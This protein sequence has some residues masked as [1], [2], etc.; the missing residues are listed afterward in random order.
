MVIGGGQTITDNGTINVGASSTVALAEANNSTT[1]IAVN[2]TLNAT[3]ATFDVT[4]NAINA[5]VTII[6]VN[7]GGIITPTGS[8]FSLP[9][10]VPYNDVAALAAGNN[11][12]F[13]QIEI[14]AGSIASGTLELDQIVIN[15]AN[16]IYVFPAGFT[17]GAGA[18]LTIGT[19]VSVVIGGGQT[20]TDNGTL[21]VGASRHRAWLRRTTRPP[22]SRSTARSMP[23]APSSTSPA[24]PSTPFV[25]I[26]QVNT[27]G[28]ITPTGSTFSL[29]L[30]VPYNDVAALA[31][32]NNQSFDQIKIDAGTLASGTVHLD[33][34]GINSANL[35]Y[36]FPAGFTIQSGAT[37]AIGTGV[38]VVVGGG[39][40]ITD[41]G[42]LNVGMPGSTVGLA[43]AN[44]STTEIAVNGTLNASGATFDITGS[45]INA[46]V[47]E[48]EVNSGGTIN[49]T[50]STFSVK[51]LSLNSGSTA[52][53][54]F[55]IF[56]GQLTVNSGATISISENTFSTTATVAAL[57]TPAATINLQNNYWTTTSAT[58]IASQIKDHSTDATRPTVSFQPFVNATAKTLAAGASAPYTTA[59]QPVALSATVSS[60]AG[61]VS[62]G[63]ETFT[64]LSGTTTI[65][66]PMMVNV[67]AGMAAANYV[68]PAGTLGGV[69]TIQ[70]I[71]NGTANFLGSIDTSQVLTVTGRA[72]GY[73][74]DRRE[75]QRP[76]SARQPSRSPSPPPSPARPA[77]STRGRRPSRFSTARH[78]SVPPSWAASP[79]ASPA[80]GYTLPAGTPGGTYTIQ[81]VYTDTVTASF[82]GSMDSS[83]LLTVVPAATSTAADDASAT[84]SAAAQSI[85]LSATV[86]SPAGAVNEGTETF[87]IF[88]GTSPIGTAVMG[89]V[90]AGVANAS[91]NLPAG[92]EV[93]TYT[94]QAA[95]TATAD[96][97]GSSENAHQL[98]VSTPRAPTTTAATDV[99]ATFS[100]LAQSV[101]LTA[102]ITSNTAG[103]VNEGT[104]TFTILEGS[105]TIGTPVTVNVAAGAASTSYGL[106]AGTAPGMYTIKA[107]YIGTTNFAG[108]SDTSHQLTINK[109]TAGTAA[110]GVMTTFSASAQSVDLSATITSGAGTVNEGTET[111]TASL[112][113]T[114]PIGPD[115]TVN[116]TAG[117]ASAIYALPA[118]TPGGTYIIQAV[119]NGTTNFLGF[120]DKSQQ[121]TISA[122]MTATDTASASATFNGAAQN[123]TLNTTITSTAGTVNEGTETFTIFSGTTQI[124]VAVTVNVTA[125]AASAVYVLPAGT[126]GG[127]YIIQAVYTGTTNFLGFTDKSQQFSISAVPSAT[128]AASASAAVS[129]A[130]QNVTLSATITSTAGTVN[131]GTETFTIFIGTTQIGLE[132]TVYVTDGG[133]SDLYVLPAGT[134]SGTYIIQAVYNGTTNFL[135]FTDRSQQL[136]ISTVITATAAASASATF[137][138]AAQNVTLSATITSTAGTVNEGTETF[139]IFRGT[140]QIG[141]AVTVNVIAGA[142][143]A[144]YVLPAGLPSGT[145]IIQAV[146]NGT[147]NF[148][149]FTEKTHLLTIGAAPSA[150]AAASASATFSAVAQNVTLSATIT[151]TA[152]T[153][154]EGT[155]TFTILDGTTPIGVAV[156]VN[157]TAGAASAV[158]VLPAGTPGGTYIIQAVYSGTT[159]FLGFTD[160]SQQLTI[161]PAATATAAASISTTFNEAA[162]NITLNATI[163]SGAGTVNEGTETFTILDGTTPIGGAVMVNVPAS[164]AS[165]V[166]VLP[167]G[168][169]GG[170]YII[171]AVYSA[172]TN[173]LGFTDKSQQLTISPAAFM[174]ATAAASISTT[175]NEGAHRKRDA[176]RHDHRRRRYGQR[177]DQRH[178]TILSGTTQIGVAVTANVTDGTASAVY[179]V[180]GGTPTGTYI[181]QAVYSATTNFLGFTDKTHQLTISPAATAT[182]AASISTTFNEAAQNVTLNATITSAAGTVNEGTETFTILSGTTTVGVAVTANVTDGTAS[183]VYVLPGGLRRPGTY[184]IQAVYSATTSFLGF[185]DKTHQLNIIP[186]TTTTKAA[187]LSAPYSSSDQSLALSA[188]ITSAA[189]IVNEGTE[190]FT[191]L[192]NSTVIG[193]PVTVNVTNAA[194]PCQLHLARRHGGDKVHHAIKDALALGRATSPSQAAHRR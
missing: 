45:A 68:L 129:A 67:T 140:T 48:I 3:S 88:S 133:V 158:Y 81:A 40:T 1:E 156:M 186:A 183:A 145:Y 37:L 2:G 172:T 54:H 83:A 39:Q 70:A 84:F 187:S 123:V 38:S 41:N 165:A 46:P 16:L 20:I 7:P 90:T 121:F 155:E 143:S 180:P 192:S 73:N 159:N 21:S 49:T 22:R 5:P 118:G 122:V 178:F 9:L 189:G 167:A 94:I 53:L 71:Y 52:T 75:Q 127:I 182:A 58:Q 103:T 166:Y 29:P 62:E 134:P 174:T 93:G 109:A 102:N 105:T 179:V 126:P 25:T 130:A 188:T 125:G 100:T 92:T 64:I 111:F 148:P 51:P 117:T 6:Q 149:G 77:P 128:A 146:Y 33:Q 163:T 114:T 144:D 132:V 151:S 36:V 24:T 161:S 160:K 80:P 61:T 169:S 112:S 13:N 116:V 69:Y 98:T 171:Q 106:P 43:E 152:G 184:I 79:R 12:S 55:D 96:F 108:S 11:Q 10:F 131:E 50:A 8:T 91:Y 119:Y 19:G 76:H 34:I 135:G 74:D 15:T 157:V 99:S 18:T 87:T 104:E 78:P 42:T 190:T 47:T 31:A 72:R 150:T 63:T 154:N 193:N 113:G 4:G 14:D 32:G 44:N 147:T 177:R 142:A 59:D 176:Q 89:T 56:T 17:I 175:F 139:T 82:V 26:I 35:S 191:I 173:F 168:T 101:M 137:N 28:I 97:L 66:T 23:P 85:A 30:F 153:V 138:A 136:T 86:T 57:G 115:V 170:T 185:T 162:Q 27:G 60:G 194:Q 181:I 65:G 107:A 110:A 124:G 120:T 164:A 95:Y 141:V